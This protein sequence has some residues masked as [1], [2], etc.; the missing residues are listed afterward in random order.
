MRFI[1]IEKAKLKINDKVFLQLEDGSFGYGRLTERKETA[2]G[3]DYTF[4]VG[5]LEDSPEETT[6]VKFVAIPKPAHV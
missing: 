5:T 3:M 6:K 1:P 4:E 2:E